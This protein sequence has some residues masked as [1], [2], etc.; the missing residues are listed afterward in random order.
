[1]KNLGFNIGLSM[2]SIE[3]ILFNFIG[4]INSI[5]DNYTIKYE[6]ISKKTKELCCLDM[7][8]SFILENQ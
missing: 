3:H 7:I 4:I 2:K 6:T 8:L 1:M 5:I